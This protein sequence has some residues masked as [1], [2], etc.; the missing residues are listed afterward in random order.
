MDPNKN[1]QEIVGKPS[2]AVIGDGENSLDTI[3]ETKKAEAI[4][5]ENKAQNVAAEQPAPA[6]QTQAGNQT[7][8]II[9]NDTPIQDPA[10]IDS[11]SEASHIEEIEKPW[12]EKVHRSFCAKKKSG[13]AGI[14]AHAKISLSCQGSYPSPCI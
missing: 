10:V 13:R 8:P 6:V 12:I 9:S 7:A 14:Q 3:L 2:E 1:S 11:P 4:F 5:T